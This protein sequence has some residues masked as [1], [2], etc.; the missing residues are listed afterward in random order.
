MV[1]MT[2]EP[3]KQTAK[4]P[5]QEQQKEQKSEKTSNKQE[6]KPAVAQP[7]EKKEEPKKPEEKKEDRVKKEEQ[8]KNI[9]SE[10]ITPKGG[11]GD[12]LD[13]FEKQYGENAGDQEMGRFQ[14]DYIL[15]MFLDGKAWN[16]KIQFE[17]TNQKARSMK[18][19]LT[20]AQGFIPKDAQ[21]VKEYD[22]PEM[23]RKVIEYK[24]ELLK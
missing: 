16:I 20:V 11:L 2:T 10:Q 24:S 4:E 5:K 12:T 14:N 18:E 15:P 17:A 8:P 9:T 23:G 13:V 19:A 3:P 6:A 22:Q 7:K 21:K 1:G